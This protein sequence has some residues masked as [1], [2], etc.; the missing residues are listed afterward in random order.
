MRI[1]S[2]N[3]ATEEIISE[4]EQISF[5]KAVEEIKKSKQAFS[6]WKN[7]SVNERAN[8]IKKIAFILKKRKNQ[9]AKIATLEMGKKFNDAIKEIEKCALVCD[10]YSEN[11]SKFLKEDIIK[12]EF[13]KS[14]VR[15]EPIGI[16]LG[17]MPWN[18]PFWQVFRFAISTLCSGNC[19]IIKHASNV[20]GCAL[21][22]QEVFKKAKFPKE[23][24][25]ILLID[26]KTAHKLIENNLVDG[27]S[28]TGSIKAG[29]L[30]AETA[31]K[32]I[33]K[34]VLELGGSDSF[35]VLED[36]NLEKTC[37]AAARARTVNAGQSCIAAKRFIIVEK[38]AKEFIKKF[39]DNIKRMKVGDP[40]DA[41]TNVGPIAREDLLKN[42]EN[43]VN[44]AK[45]KGV[46]ILCGGHRL[47]KKGYFY[48]PTV[49]TGV[50]ENMQI[51]K[52]EVFGPV[53][54]V[55]IVKNEKEAI[56]EANKL[57]FG[58]GASI[59]TKNIARGE[60]IAKEIEAGNVFVNEIPRS[61]IRLPFGG[62]KNSGYGREL[63][64]YGI[65]EFINIKTMAVNK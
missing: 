13:Y 65:K 30:V 22:I 62:I 8:Y 63:S 54:N 41:D 33:K 24:F 1:K 44:D 57:S 19:V 15:F 48:A 38:I 50:K 55:I 23:V 46:K 60:K 18:Y 64:H 12:T 21:A 9:L 42:L 14:Y 31:G 61:D 49:L 37:V 40:F 45:K 3:P 35:I 56:K 2:I 51:N 32:K 27:V 39:V 6:K 17:I 53:A 4:Y 29:K 7:L 43:Q 10:Y 25:K 16:V 34:C 52:E 5:E 20:S 36:A 28:I 11:S 47:N 58:L 59:W 26:S